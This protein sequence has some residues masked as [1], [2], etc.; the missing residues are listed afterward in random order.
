MELKF[1]SVDAVF[2]DTIFKF[3][4]ELFQDL[5]CLFQRP[6]DAVDLVGAGPVVEHVL[7]AHQLDHGLEPTGLLDVP[8]LVLHH[9]SDD[10]LLGPMHVAGCESVTTSG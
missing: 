1:L 8:G 4:L 2:H 10:E 9:P 5:L 7:G 3:L 6:V